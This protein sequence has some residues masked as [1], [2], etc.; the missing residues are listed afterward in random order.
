MNR[1]SRVTNRA[2]AEQRIIHERGFGRIVYGLRCCFPRVSRLVTT[3][4][5]SPVRLPVWHTL[6]A[7]RRG[8]TRFNYQL[9]GLVQAGNA[10]DYLSDHEVLGTWRINKD[11]DGVIRNKLAFCLLMKR[12]GIPTPEI[13]GMIQKGVF[14]P[15]D[16]WRAM[17]PTVFLRELF[18]PGERLVLKPI[19]GFHGTGLIILTRTDNG[20]QVN[21]DDTLSHALAHTISTLDHYLV[22]EFV[23][24]GEYGAKLYPHTVNTIRAMTFWDEETA[25]PFVARVVQRIGTSRSF[26]VDN[27]KAGTGGLSASIEDETG[28]LGPGA[29]ATVEGRVSWHPRHPETHAPIQG[30]VVPSW[31]EIRKKV[32]EYADK[33]AFAPCIAWDIV[34]TESG[35]S[36]LE[37][38][39]TG[40]MPVL[41]VH[42][43]ML[44]DSRIKR[45]YRYHGVIS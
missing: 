14:Y 45:F 15:L 16:S 22:S 31:L 7:W 27:F 24:Q 39:A 20:Y 34:P 41:Q 44:I 30:V 4:L 2:P 23:T 1:T 12:F 36:I 17:S 18:R 33:F 29:M 26:P 10:A 32:L 13:L 25:E 8:L 40:G 37:G 38:N 6:R 5:A 11:F 21:G 19:S 3:E 9:Y 28:M 43:P 42:E 35:F